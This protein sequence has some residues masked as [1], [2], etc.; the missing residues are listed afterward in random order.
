MAGA[1]K[2]LEAVSTQLR[3]ARAE[4]RTKQHEIERLNAT[5]IDH[6]QQLRYA[7]KMAS[8]GALI[9]GIAHEIKTP[10]GAIHSMQDTLTKAL[11]RL[12]QTIA[13]VCPAGSPQA[14][15]LQ[16]AL[17]VIEDANQVFAAGS[18]RTLEIVQRVRKFARLDLED[19][20]A[21]DLHTELDD[22]LLLL[23]HELRSRIEVVKH[24]GA[25]PPVVCHAGQI[26]QVFLNLLVNA[27]QAIEG[28]G[29]ITLTTAQQNGC[30]RVAISD[31]GTGIDPALLTRVFE[32][33]FTTK[34]AGL[35][36]GLGLP[37]SHQIVRDHGGT[38]EI[39]ST[40][41]A[42]TTVTVVLPIGSTAKPKGCGR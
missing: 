19:M 30:V 11:E 40:P 32:M 38:L 1:A 22:T 12:K 27:V 31:S 15:S 24:Y 3:A 5:C 13:E 28:P 10:V 18:S 36:S 7:Q 29:T 25:L 8:L 9:A 21:T 39:E 26:N 6:Q 35:G 2:D 34:Q 17:Q 23:N 33:G 37:I 20:A 4:L 14:R 41:G 42:G 16:G